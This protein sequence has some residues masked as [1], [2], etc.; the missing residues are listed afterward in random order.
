MS[1]CQARKQNGDF[2]NNF[3]K[4][5]EKTCH[6]LNHKQQFHSNKKVQKGG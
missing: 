4:N 6:I 5:G 3:A 1:L 2:C